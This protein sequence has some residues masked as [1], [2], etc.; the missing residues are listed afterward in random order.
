[1]SDLICRDVVVEVVVGQHLVGDGGLAP[2]HQAAVQPLDQLGVAVSRRHRASFR[3]LTRSTS[4][5]TAASAA[6]EADG[7]ADGQISQYS[8]G[9]ERRR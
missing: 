5:N 4:S 9:E 2:S 8:D 1:V 3:C 7:R 6:G